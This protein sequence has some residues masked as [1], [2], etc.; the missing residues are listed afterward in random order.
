MQ[1]RIIFNQFVPALMFTSWIYFASTF[2]ISLPFYTLW[3]LLKL[4]EEGQKQELLPQLP[5]IYIYNKKGLR[6]QVV[7]DRVLLSLYRLSITQ[8]PKKWLLLVERTCLIPYLRLPTVPAPGLAPGPAKPSLGAAALILAHQ[9]QL[10]VCSHCLVR[11]GRTLR[12]HE[13]NFHRKKSPPQLSH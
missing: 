5:I 3:L 4:V 11:V 13:L 6:G 7:Q 12:H 2:Y 10:H 9:S 8:V 1:P